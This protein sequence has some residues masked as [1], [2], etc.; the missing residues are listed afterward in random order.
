MA[1]PPR[2]LS[3][4]ASAALRA[5][6]GG[7]AGRSCW[8]LWPS[9][10]AAPVAGA[11]ASVSACGC[12]PIAL[13]T[14]AFFFSKQVDDKK[15]TEK[16]TWLKVEDDDTGV[17]G[18]TSF[19]QSLAGTVVSARLPDVGDRL[20]AGA[21]LAE[22]ETTGLVPRMSRGGKNPRTFEVAAPVDCEVIEVNE[23]LSEEPELVNN[24]AED[25]GWLVKVK[26]TGDSSLLMDLEGY[27]QYVDTL[28]TI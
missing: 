23:M 16:H 25:D 12:A 15:Y 8:R 3:A 5:G 14:R 17:V 9:P 27:G 4:A 7:A 19:G 6:R 28:D 20:T 11:A 22:L 24:G 26:I 18:L 1:A 2:F 21:S 10:V 13:Q